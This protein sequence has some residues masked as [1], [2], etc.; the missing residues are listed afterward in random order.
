LLA[1]PAFAQLGDYMGPSVLSRGAAASAAPWDSLTFRPYININ[2]MYNSNLATAGP[3]GGAGESSGG[4][5]GEGALGLYGYKGTERTVVGLN[6]RG[7][8]RRYDRQSAYDGSNQFLTFGVSHQPGRHVTITA[9][10]GAGTYTRQFSYLG[11]FGFYDPSFAEIPQDELLDN[12]T[13]YLTTMADVTY[14]KSARLSFNIGG[15]GFVIRRQKSSL[16]GVVGGTARAD[17]TYRL[18]RRQTVAVDYLYT[19]FGYDKAFGSGD[20]QSVGANYSVAVARRTELRFRAGAL[21]VETLALAKVALD[22]DIA[23]ILGRAYGV[24]AFHALYTQPSYSGQIVQRFRHG[25]LAG[26]YSHGAMPGNGIYLTSRQNAATASYSYTGM[27]RWSLISRFSYTDMNSVG[28]DIGAYRRLSGGGGATRSIARTNLYL[29]ARADV[30][31]TVAGEAFS[32]NYV[33]ATVGLAFAPG[34]VPLRLW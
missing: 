10:A 6:Y 32:R 25:S 28:Q 9:R 23:A 15:T 27:R 21:R 3:A 13:T 14:R 22:P 26:G 19:H 30:Q 12:R 29:T 18:T 33:T 11:T 34:D 1:L 20:L 7:D 5:G 2:A 16:Y 4:F 17:T 8:Y 31:R 24:A